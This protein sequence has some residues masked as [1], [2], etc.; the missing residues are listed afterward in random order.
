MS[1]SSLSQGILIILWLI[2]VL[3]KGAP[4]TTGASNC[5]D[6]NVSKRASTFNNPIFWEDLADLDVIRVGTTYYYSA[7]TMHYSPGAPLLQSFDLI[8]WEF[9]GHSVPSLDFGDP[10]DYDLTTGRAYVRGIWASSIKF[11]ESTNTWYWIGCVD[12]SRTYVYTSPAPT[13]PWVQRSIISTCYYDAGLLIDDTDTMYVAYGSTTINVAQLSSDGL[14][15]VSTQPVFTS[16]VGAI[17]GSR[18]YQR[19]GNYYILNDL[20]ATS[21]Y[22]AM[23][24]SGPFGPY[25]TR[26]L[27]LSPVTPIPDAGFPHQGGLI[28]TPEG[29]WYY[30]AFNDAYPSG[31]VPVLMPITW[32]SDGWPSAELGSGNTWEATYPLPLPT[33][34]VASPVGTDT[35][36]SIGPNWEWNH[37]PDT[38]K[39]SISNGLKLGT[40]T[41]TSDL[42]S[43]RN[44]IT[45]RILGPKANG[46]IEL[47]VSGMANG[48]RAGLAM[49]RDT[50]A[51][52]AINDASGAKT[53][54]M[55]NGLTMNTTG[56]TTTSTGSVVQSATFSG[57]TIYLRCTADIQPA[58]TQ[59][60]VFSYSTDGTT[61]R[62]L[63][64][65][66][67][68]NPDWEF[69]MA[70]RFGIFNFA[71]QA[72][73]GSVTVKSFTM[74]PA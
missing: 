67:K 43:A 25:T 45:H 42:Y 30:M 54:E 15:Q 20:P 3:A 36:T 61:F 18:F 69:F 73:G 74:E 70:Y 17:E 57:N 59:S 14:S 65:A 60:A 2:V 6:V 41:V 55:V 22:V 21:E 32:S 31:R 56:W 72:L 62:T 66:L 13:G 68:L 71:M 53:I 12:F 49:L 5:T 29:N 7:S 1:R 9:I 44:T 8:N 33:V 52:I 10:G 11:R 23:S 19:N 37:N 27:T 28:D 24:T 51:Y 35:F 26:G 58:G 4:S 47:D 38:T 64:N 50:S 46:T 16:T 34:T 39:F 48:D 63:G 40:A